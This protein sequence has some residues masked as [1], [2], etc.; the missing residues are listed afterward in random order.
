MPSKFLS[1]LPGEPLFVD[2]ARSGF[3]RKRL[4]ELKEQVG[5]FYFE[6]TEKFYEVVEDKYYK[7]WGFSS[8]EDYCD[9]ELGWGKRKG[10]YFV[11]F[12]KTLV[13]EA[14]LPKEQLRD[15]DW[16]KAAAISELPP[17]ELNDKDVRDKW[18][19][20]A[21]SDSASTLKSKVGAV[22]ERRRI[23][24]EGGKVSALKPI[25][26]EEIKEEEQ[27]VNKTFRLYPAQLQNV[28]LAIKN[29]MKTSGSDKE[30]HNIDLICT[31]FNVSRG[32]DADVK[33]NRMLD[34]INRAFG[35][36]CVAIAIKGKNE[37]IVYGAEIAKRY[38]IE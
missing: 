28:E 20:T 16:S 33:L 26:P 38:G 8:F 34:S 35:V 32:E 11:K 6:M 2:E 24:R 3:V 19:E 9:K 21:K 23:A 37:E 4:M 5:T 7:K 27:L 14:G 18:I 29:S 1:E 10:W 30:G 22:K 17:E 36:E 31:E 25:A 15:I 13:M 12:F